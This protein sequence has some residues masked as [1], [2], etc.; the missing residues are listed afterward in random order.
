M[1]DY[2][3]KVVGFDERRRYREFEN[4]IKETELQMFD[5]ACRKMRQYYTANLDVSLDSTLKKRIIQL[6]EENSMIKKKLKNSFPVHIVIYSV[7]CSI[8]IGISL[9]LLILRFGCNIYTVD[10]YYI[11]CSLLTALTL[12][13]T[14]LA[15]IK[16]W[17]GYL[18]G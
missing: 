10:P 9:T 4:G 2:N 18:N 5:E 1:S 13:F 17:K 15:A 8:V 3:G 11:I 6:E 16:D 12:F 14:A 7:I